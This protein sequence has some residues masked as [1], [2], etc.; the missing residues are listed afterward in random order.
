MPPFPSEFNMTFFLWHCQRSGWVTV[1]G[2]TS[3]DVSQALVVTTDE[4]YRRM[5]V[6]MDHEGNFGVVP[7]PVDMIYDLVGVK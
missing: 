7:V 4:A 5:E 1:T 2:T 6:A 3:T